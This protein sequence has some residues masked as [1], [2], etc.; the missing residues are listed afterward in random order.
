MR[1]RYFNIIGISIFQ[2]KADAKLI[3]YADT[4]LSFSVAFQFLEL[5]AA[6]FH[7]GRQFL[8]PMDDAQPPPSLA[9]D[10]NRQL[11]GK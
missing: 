2:L 8:S 3:V 10:V 7:Y 4:I 5:I 6:N 9:L 11:L 1:T